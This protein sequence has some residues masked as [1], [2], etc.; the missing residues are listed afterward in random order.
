M[1][2]YWNFDGN[3]NDQTGNYS[4]AAAG[5]TG[6]SYVTGLIQ[7]PVRLASFNGTTS[8]IE[9]PMEMFWKFC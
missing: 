1:V 7:L 8:L 4:A 3:A 9:I 6:I 5:I 2:A